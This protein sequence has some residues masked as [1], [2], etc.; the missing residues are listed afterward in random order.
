LE[1]EKVKTKT[2]INGEGGA[3]NDGGTETKVLIFSFAW[4]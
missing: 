2:L 4:S 3:E 1:I